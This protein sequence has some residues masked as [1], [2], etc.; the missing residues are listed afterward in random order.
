M[1]SSRMR[2]KS[3]SLVHPDAAPFPSR[4]APPT[5]TSSA[6]SSVARSPTLTALRVPAPRPRTPLHR[7]TVARGTPTGARRPPPLQRT[8]SH[9]ASF[10][11]GSTLDFAGLGP[12]LR[13]ARRWARSAHLHEVR[14]ESCERRPGFNGGAGSENGAPAGDG[15]LTAPARDDGGGSGEWKAVVRGRGM[16]RPL[17]PLRVL[18]GPPA[19]APA[20]GGFGGGIGERDEADD[21]HAWVD[22]DGGASDPA[23]A[24]DGDDVFR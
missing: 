15:W 12:V 13:S 9:G 2:W 18:V 22:T 4:R 20:L 11:S 21:V 1:Q 19:T 8:N 14:S 5:R 3:S 17:A 23:G 10:G 7:T 16:R 24:S 6:E